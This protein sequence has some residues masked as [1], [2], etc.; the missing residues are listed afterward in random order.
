MTV[1]KNKIILCLECKGSIEYCFCSCPYCGKI[2]KNCHCEL[3]S[4]K[5]IDKISQITH[6]SKSNLLKQS[7]KLS[8]M[9]TKEDSWWRLEKWQI[10]RS[11]F[12]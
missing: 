6:H 5:G 9:N 2:T 7:K 11:K 12:P 8:I 1:T 10:G 4:S 3:E